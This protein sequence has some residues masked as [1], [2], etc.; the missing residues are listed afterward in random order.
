MA[1]LWPCTIKYI[2]STLL[3]TVNAEDRIYT[4]CCARA[5][6]YRFSSVMVNEYF[7]NISYILLYYFYALYIISKTH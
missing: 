4:W 6:T 7:I 2:S 3:L 1:R 5:G